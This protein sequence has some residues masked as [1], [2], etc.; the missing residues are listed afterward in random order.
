MYLQN[1]GAAGSEEIKARRQT[2]EM[3]LSWPFIVGRLGLSASATI[4]ILT[5][6][7]GLVKEERRSF[8][9][10]MESEKRVSE[11]H[12]MVL[13]FHAQG[14]INLML[15]FSKRLAS[16]GL[17]TPTRSIEDY[18]ERFRILVTALMEKHNRSNHPAKLLIYDSVFPW[19]QDLD[20]HL[21]LDGVPFFT[22]SRDVSAIYCHFYQG[23]MKWMASQRPLIKTIG[24]TVPSMYL[25]QR[26]EDDKDYG[27]SLFQQNLGITGR[28]ADGGT[29]MGLR[30]SNNH[31]MLLVRELEK[32]K[33]P[34]NFTEETSEKGL[35]G[36]WCCQ[37]EVLAHKSVGRFMTHCGWNS[38]LEAMSLGVPMIAMPRFSDQTTNAKFVEDVWQVGV[39][40]KAMKNG[41]L[42]ERK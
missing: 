4:E 11:T 27:L 31:F 32:K 3:T 37:L 5:S 25:E 40:V 22:Q 15:Q 30:R 28:R 7:S 26:L 20:E 33:L 18:L 17:K 12:I 10:K 39:R 41:L 14:H 35:V 38:T 9:R 16:K 21:G 24:P 8:W 36:S 1:E 19:A 6:V 13:P 42:R 34:D 23:V 29:S 2:H